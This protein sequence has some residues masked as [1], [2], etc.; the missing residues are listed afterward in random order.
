MRSRWDAS[1]HATRWA[2]ARRRLAGR[3]P[4]R[5]P[6]H[7]AVPTPC[8][9]PRPHGV[10]IDVA[11]RWH[12][13]SARD[14]MTFESSVRLPAAQR[15]ARSPCSPSPWMARSRR[16]PPSACAPC[17]ASSDLVWRRGRRFPSGAA[18]QR[19][20]MKSVW[21]W[22]MHGGRAVTQCV[23][24]PRRL[25]PGAALRDRSGAQARGRRARRVVPAAGRRR[26]RGPGPSPARGRRPHRDR[27]RRE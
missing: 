26:R 16:P 14:L 8:R 20:R 7:H 12:R 23:G 6:L 19:R 10:H 2:H 1:P 9:H 25:G 22:N 4:A 3:K 24:W 13:V 15:S 11:V 5:P 18:S 27:P 17:R 21:S